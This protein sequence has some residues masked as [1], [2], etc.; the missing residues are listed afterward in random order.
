M[1]SLRVKC[2]RTELPPLWNANEVRLSLEN[3]QKMGGGGRM[4]GRPSAIVRVAAQSRH[5]DTPCQV[6]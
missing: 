4:A 6:C 5:T 1:T 2:V 3:H